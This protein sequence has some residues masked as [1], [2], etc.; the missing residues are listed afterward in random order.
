[1]RSYAC[2]VCSYGYKPALGDP[3]SGIPP[4]TLFEDLPDDWRCPWCGA[5]KAQFVP[6]EEQQDG[7]PERAS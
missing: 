3:D 1:M 4:G 5:T 7:L 6:E 2:T